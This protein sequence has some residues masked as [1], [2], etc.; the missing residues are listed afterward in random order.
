MNLLIT[1]ESNGMNMF[2]TDENTFFTLKRVVDI[3]DIKSL[4]EPEDVVVELT[5]L[6]KATVA[7]LKAEFTKQYMED[8]AAV[9]GLT[10]DDCEY[11]WDM[12]KYYISTLDDVDEIIEHLRLDLE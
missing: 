10:K 8:I 11:S 12:N 9:G 2:F 6:Y 7:E 3:E 1:A 5:E 4:D